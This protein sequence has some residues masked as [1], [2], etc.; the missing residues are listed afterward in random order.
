MSSA[1]A[2]AAVTPAASPMAMTEGDTRKDDIATDVAEID[3]PATTRPAGP[4]LGTSVRHG[5]S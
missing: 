4:S 5:T 3:R 2:S 1:A